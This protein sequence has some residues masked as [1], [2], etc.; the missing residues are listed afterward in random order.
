MALLRLA[1]ISARPG[2]SGLLSEVL[3]NVGGA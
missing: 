3:D 2:T 1:A